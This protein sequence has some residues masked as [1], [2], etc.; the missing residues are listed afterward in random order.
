M[1][2]AHEK[3]GKNIS[4]FETKIIFEMFFFVLC[5]CV[6]LKCESSRNGRPDK[7]K[8][9][10]GGVAPSKVMKEEK[11]TREIKRKTSDRKKTR[12]P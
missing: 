2:K 1:M 8:S 9:N 5:V 12:K 7:G 10:A 11:K 6:F 4:F 3:K